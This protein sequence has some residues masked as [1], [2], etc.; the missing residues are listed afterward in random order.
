MSIGTSGN[1]EADIYMGREAFMHGPLLVCA[2]AGLTVFT[3]CAAQQNAKAKADSMQL[4]LKATLDSLITLVTTWPG[5]TAS[6]RPR[7][8]SHRQ[9]TRPHP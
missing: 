7:N 8:G 1:V 3:G 9:T 2:F 4:L 5:V 6:T